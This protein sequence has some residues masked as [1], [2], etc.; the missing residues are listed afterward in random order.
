VPNA[1]GR[2]TAARPN[3]GRRCRELQRKIGEVARTLR[4]ND[5][6][7]LALEQ[8]HARSVPRAFL[9]AASAFVDFDV[10]TLAR[11]FAPN[12]GD[13][14]RMAAHDQSGHA[15]TTPAHDD[16][17][18]IIEESELPAADKQYWRDVVR[19]R[20]RP[21]SDVARTRR[22]AAE[23]RAAALAALAAR[24]EAPTPDA[25]LEAA[26]TAHELDVLSVAPGSRLLGSARAKLDRA[27]PAIILDRT[28]PPEPA[29]FSKA[30]ELG[31]FVVERPDPGAALG[32]GPVGDDCTCAAADVDEA[33]VAERFPLGEAYVTGYGPRQRRE[34]GASLFAAEFLAPVVVVCEAFRAGRP[35]RDIA[36]DLGVSPTVV[37]GQLTAGLL[38]PVPAAEDATP[39]G[40]AAEPALHPKQRAAKEALPG[41]VV[42]DAGPGT[43]KTRTLVERVRFL[44]DQRGVPADRCSG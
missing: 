41:P 11:C 32:C 18:T 29:R 16:F 31:H 19:R 40:P 21:M 24:G 7:L 5:E 6:V 9:T 35:A 10:P 23:L 27:R 22:L 37:H 26:L 17:L 36:A 42:V 39:A 2:A 15:P 38:H 43:G 44:V 14:A 28:L 4:V 34:V 33:P 30:H 12:T 20:G 3:F 1:P 13:V 25:V 8:G